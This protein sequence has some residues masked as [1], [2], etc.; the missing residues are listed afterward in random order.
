VDP[1]KVALEYQVA[2]F[3]NLGVPVASEK[4]VISCQDEVF[5]GDCRAK[6]GYLFIGWNFTTLQKQRVATGA[7][8]VRLQYKIRVGETAPISGKLDQ[9][10]GVVREN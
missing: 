3:S 9:I 1:S 6:R 5:G 8:V 2:Y 4:R 10:W 7:Y